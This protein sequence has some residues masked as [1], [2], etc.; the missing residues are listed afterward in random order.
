M[1]LNLRRNTFFNVIF[2]QQGISITELMVVAAVSSI[3]AM[4]VTSIVVNNQKDSL[5]I[6]EKLAYSEIEG[7]L[8]SYANND[9]CKYEFSTNQANYTF[10]SAA[11][12]PT[13]DIS[14]SNLYKN[15]TSSQAVLKVND[16]VGPAKLKLSSIALKNLNLIAP[17]KYSSTLEIKVQGGLQPYKPIQ[18]NIIVETIT[19]GNQVQLVGCL[20]TVRKRDIA[21]IGCGTGFYLEGFDENGGKKCLPFPPPAAATPPPAAATPPTMYWQPPVADGAP[22]LWPE[23][24]CITCAG[25]GVP[26]PPGNTCGGGATSYNVLVSGRNTTTTCAQFNLADGYG[27]PLG[28]GLCPSYT[29]QKYTQ[30]CR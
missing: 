30:Y 27:S 20:N 23:F 25:N 21:S 18:Q 9:I 26:I 2:T 16:P 7:E 8:L 15:A 22:Y 24:F 19:V 10:N 12:P 13:Q 29:Y 11:F 6:K 17:F 5:A 28:S 14:I 3:L 4:G 1:K